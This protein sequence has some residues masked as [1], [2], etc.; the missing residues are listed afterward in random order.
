MEGASGPTLWHAGMRK[1]GSA[2]GRELFFNCVLTSFQA[3]GGD[4]RCPQACRP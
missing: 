3:M 1:Q 4:R 2:T